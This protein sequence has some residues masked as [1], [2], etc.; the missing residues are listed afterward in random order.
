MNSLREQVRL[1]LPL[2]LPW[3]S[4]VSQE[5]IDELYATRV[6]LDKLYEVCA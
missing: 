4:D 2:L 1:K 6:V 5:S 3:R